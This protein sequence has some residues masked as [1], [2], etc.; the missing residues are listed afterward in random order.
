MYRV[1]PCTY[2]KVTEKKNLRECP[3]VIV[4]LLCAYGLSSFL[5]KAPFYQ[6]LTPQTR[7]REIGLNMVVPKFQY[8][9]PTYFL[10]LRVVTQLSFVNVDLQM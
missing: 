5:F 1:S 8:H 4:N 9:I 6:I 7:F 10:T 2:I 3:A